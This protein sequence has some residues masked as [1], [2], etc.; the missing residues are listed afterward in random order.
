MNYHT[1]AQHLYLNNNDEDDNIL[2]ERGVI[3]D[4]KTYRV[5]TY[6]MDS[7]QIAAASIDHSFDVERNT[8]EREKLYADAETRLCLAYLDPLAAWR[9][10]SPAV[11]SQQPTNDAPSEPQTLA[12][13]YAAYEARV[14]SAYKNPPPVVPIVTD[15]TLQSL[16]PPKSASI[17]DERAAT[18]QAYDERVTRQWKNPL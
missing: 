5:P 2:D 12:D 16:L 17:T 3:R 8:S 1:G 4:G 7:A 9:D 13:A 6:M 11:A 18:Y 15:R 14:T 10:P